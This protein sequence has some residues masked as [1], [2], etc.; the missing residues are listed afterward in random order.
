M[1][2]NNQ[3]ME[4]KEFVRN[5]RQQLQINLIQQKNKGIE[6]AAV[7]AFMCLFMTVLAVLA[8]YHSEEVQYYSVFYGYSTWIWIGILWILI[9]AHQLFHHDAISMYPGNAITRY[10]GRILADHIHMFLYMLCV[11][12][13]YMLQCGLLWLLLQGRAGVDVTVVFDLRYLAVGL[14]RI[15]VYCMALYG[16]LA[17][18]L[19]LDARFGNWFRC[20]FYAGIL[21]L[22]VVCV[23]CRPVFMAEIM[24]WIQGEQKDFTSYLSVLALIW[25]VCIVAAGILACYVHS[26]KIGYKANYMMLLI[27]GVC[28]F[29]I[30]FLS[31]ITIT[32]ED[33]VESESGA[34]GNGE[35]YESAGRYG[36]EDYYSSILIRLPDH[37][38]YSMDEDMVEVINSANGKKA[39]TLCQYLNNGDNIGFNL[40]S[41]S[42]AAGMEIPKGID[43][44]GIDEEHGMLIFQCHNVRINGQDV[45]CDF[46]EDL[47]NNLRQT[48]DMGKIS[49]K[50][51]GNLKSMICIDFFPSADRFL[52]RGKRDMTMKEYCERQPYFQTTL[53]VS[54]ARYE[55]LEAEMDEETGE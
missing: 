12:L 4:R 24:G 39:G 40:G 29:C 26:W 37:N 41:K 21:S 46:M 44:S 54:D 14:L 48:E 55:A 47:Q 23:Q 49:L 13:L 35:Q 27:A 1:K 8:F 9:P 32:V 25:L 17:L 15:S 7:V 34:G 10:L 2:Q 11:G 19:A 43:L 38:S 36:A 18:L 51:A 22:I 28:L 31:G 33:T 50:Y 16:G 3:W 20:I 30:I 42:E 45:Y 53:L 52:H 6:S 5:V